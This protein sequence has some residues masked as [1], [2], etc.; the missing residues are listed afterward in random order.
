MKTPGPDHPIAIAPA[1]GR[2]RV[3]YAG[4]VIADT[5][6]ALVLTEATLPPVVYFPR[7]DV[8]M[9]YFARTDR[10]T[11]CPYK[12]DAAYYTLNMDGEMSENA[13]W[14][15]ESPFPAVSQIEGRLAF[16]PDRVD[17]Y[18]YDPDA[19]RG[20]HRGPVRWDEESASRR[21][22]DEVVRHTDSGSGNSQAAHWPPNVSPPPE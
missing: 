8:A 10:R 13:V 19:P 18:A 7:A 3:E 4:H 9:E 21:E 22:V 12:G 17:I 14:T 6:D 5:Q 16:Y 11:H 1:R 15:Y 20:A 2:V